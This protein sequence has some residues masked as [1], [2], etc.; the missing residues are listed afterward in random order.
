MTSTA[1]S[2]DNGHFAVTQIFAT[3]AGRAARHSADL[4]QLLSRRRTGSSSRRGILHHAHRPGLHPARAT[5][6]HDDTREEP[7]TNRQ[8]GT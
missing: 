6:R 7:Q 8:A 5:A 1:A 2:P 3:G 4:G